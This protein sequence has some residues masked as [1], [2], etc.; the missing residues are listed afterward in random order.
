[1]TI[2]T[3]D[4]L[5]KNLSLFFQLHSFCKNSVF[6]TEAGY[7]DFLADSRLKILLRIFLVLGISVTWN[8]RF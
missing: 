3:A 4:F 7:S 2:F 5:F 1:M 8:F 6:R